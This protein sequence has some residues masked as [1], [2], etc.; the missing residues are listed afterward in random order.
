MIYPTHA[1][2]AGR[3]RPT[4]LL[5]ALAAATLAACGGGPPGGGGG[6][7]RGAGPVQVDTA[8]VRRGE[9]VYYDRFPGTVSPLDEV[10]VRPQVA[11][12]ITAVHHTEGHPVRRGQR[13]YTIDTRQYAAAAESAAAE[14][15]SARAQLALSEKDVERY[16]RLAEAEAIAA[17]TLDQ[18]ETA[19]EASR[20]ALAGA[21]ARERQART[22]L[23]YAVVHA[24][25]S[26]ITGLESAKVGTQV[27]PGSPVLVTI[28]KQDPMGVDVAAPQKL[29][30]RLRR[31]E[32]APGEQPDSLFRLR[33][34]DGTAYA[35]YGRVYALQQAVDAATG[36]L[37]TR[38]RF[39]NPEG[40][41]VPG[42]N[43]EV[44]VLNPASGQATSI[45]TTALA[46]QMGERYVFVVQ[47]TLALR[48]K[49]RTGYNFRDRTV[50]TEGLDAG[51][52]VASG[53]LNKLRDSASVR[54]IKVDR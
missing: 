50:I 29:I 18:A 7:G 15:E 19:L 44:E 6:G 16:R 4:R 3:L 25:M 17:Q 36:T 38:L 28:A 31:A 32:N 41:L 14:V 1:T 52:V 11:G 48:R 30:P 37:L 24:P 20:Q 43:L 8:H 26:G 12:Y 47:D 5:L 49:V 35:E 22:Q 54:P 23:D 40:I 46:D 13:L 21:Q 10:E 9:V 34:P 53:G 42:M 33:L 45:P 2:L 39:P 27:A 51:E